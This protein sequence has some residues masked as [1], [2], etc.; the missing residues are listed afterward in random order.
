MTRANSHE[1]LLQCT[2][3]SH[4]GLAL[5]ICF[6]VCKSARVPL[7]Y[8]SR[9]SPFACMIQGLGWASIFQRLSQRG[10]CIYVHSCGRPKRVRAG[11]SSSITRRPIST[12]LVA[13]GGITRTP[14]ALAT[15]AEKGDLIFA[16]IA[17]VRLFKLICVRLK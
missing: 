7:M 6:C 3:R 12:R 8:I 13:S 5:N 17:H 16:F 2:K 1:R 11:R 4:G 10:E 15:P 9:T 14:S